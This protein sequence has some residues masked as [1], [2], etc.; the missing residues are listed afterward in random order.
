MRIPR[1][2]R[3]RS[4]VDASC[5]LRPP[6]THPISAS[7]PRCTVIAI[8]CVCGAAAISRMGCL[9]SRIR[10]GLDDRG[11]FPPSAQVHVVAIAT[12]QPVDDHG[13][14]TRWS[15]DDSATALLHQ[16]TAYAMSRSTMGRMRDDA[17]LTPHR[18]VSGLHSHDHAFEAKAPDI[19][20]LSVNALPC[21]QHGRFVICPDAKTGMPMLQR[22]YP[23]QLRQPGKPDK[24]EQEDLRHGTRVL[25]ASF[26]V[27]TGQV[28]WHL[29]PTR[30]RADVA[31]PLA[32]VGQPLPDMHRYAWGVEHLNTPWSLD[33][34]R[35]VAAWGDLPDV[36]K[37]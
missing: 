20:H 36:A 34:C 22:P 9:G 16:A 27:P 18:S 3:W 1:R 11:A 19:C 35:L 8:R 17:D 15:L 5:A 33:V 14:A 13:T 24:R 7:P 2:K 32:N 25:L 30:T 37:A 23:P 31:T 26:G 6:T 29:S 21:F 10:H 28:V 12:R 4:V